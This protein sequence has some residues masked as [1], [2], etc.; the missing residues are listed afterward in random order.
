MGGKGPMKR[1]STPQEIDAGMPGAMQIDYF[2]VY[3]GTINP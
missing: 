3:S 2:R 1:N